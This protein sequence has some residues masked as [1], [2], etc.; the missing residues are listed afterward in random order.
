MDHTGIMRSSSF[1]AMDCG[2]RIGYP[3]PGRAFP[4]IRIKINL[5]IEMDGKETAGSCVHG[6][7]ECIFCWI[8]GYLRD[9]PAT[10]AAAS[11]PGKGCTPKG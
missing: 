1:T 10:S 8:Q 2:S 4:W 6:L 11:M 5:Y 7:K 3:S 9:Q